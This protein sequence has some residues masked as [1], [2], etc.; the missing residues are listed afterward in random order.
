MIYRTKNLSGG[1]RTA[2]GTLPISTGGAAGGAWIWTGAGA[3]AGGVMTI[4]SWLCAGPRLL[5]ILY[6]R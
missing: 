3:G 6:P 4:G 1:T 2:T 5:G